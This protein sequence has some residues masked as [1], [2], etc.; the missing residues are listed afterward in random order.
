MSSERVA[1]IVLAAGKGTRMKSDRPKVLH[2]LGGR[3]LIRYVLDAVAKLAPARTVV[4]LAPG[5][6]AVAQEAAGTQVAIQSVP[7]GTGHAALAAHPALADLIAEDR[8]DDVLVVFGDTPLLATATLAAMLAE[9]RR[10]PEAGIVVLGM[11]P[12]DPGAYGRLVCGKDGMLEAI[13]EAKDA[14]ESQ[15]RIG[16]CNSGVMAIAARHLGALLAEIGADAHIG[17]F[18]EIKQTVIGRGAKANHLSYIGDA[19][20]GA[21]ANIGAGTITCNYDGVAKTLTRIGE[22]AF[23]GS[24]TVLVAP[25]TVGAGAYIAAGSAITRD[26]ADDA[27]AIGRAQQID[28]PGRGKLIRKMKTAEKLARQGK[29]QG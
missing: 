23:I 26:V 5:M 20:I 18:V 21:G 8:V 2:R 3:P 29:V 27:L 16:L 17:N 14:T 22:G 24:N 4:V 28:K 10:A 6:E 11:R 12:A 13:V 25:V 9:R 1:A 15:R 7:L 19:E